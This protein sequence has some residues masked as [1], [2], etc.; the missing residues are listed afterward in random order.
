LARILRD[1]FRQNA[2]Q[3]A[4]VHKAG[5]LSGVTKSARSYQDWVGQSQSPQAYGKIYVNEIH[6]F[7][8]LSA[9]HGGTG[10]PRIGKSISLGS[11]IG[12]VNLPIDEP[13]V[14]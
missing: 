3:A 7:G 10:L 6:V 13:I 9:R 4:K 8:G 11:W 5:H 1:G 2:P 14:S 12:T